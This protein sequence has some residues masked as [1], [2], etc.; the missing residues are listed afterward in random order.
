MGLLNRTARTTQRGKEPGPFSNRQSRAVCHS[1]FDLNAFV[2]SAKLNLFSSN[3]RNALRLIAQANRAREARRWRE[4]GELYAA[5]L[6]RQPGNPA[7]HIQCG[8]MFKEAGEYES[9]ETHYLHARI[10]APHDADLHLQLGHFYKITGRLYESFSAYER[11]AEL[12]PDWNEPQRELKALHV[13]VQSRLASHSFAEVIE[14][15]DTKS[16]V[17]VR[18]ATRKATPPASA[19]GVGRVLWLGSNALSSRRE[20]ESLAGLGFEIIFRDVAASTPD[21]GGAPHFAEERDV[22]LATP[23]SSSWREMGLALRHDFAC[24]VVENDVGIF[25]EYI[26]SFP[27][28]IVFRSYGISRLLGD[29]LWDYGSLELARQ[30]SNIVYMPTVEQVVSLEA[31]WLQ[32]SATVLPGLHAVEADL[33]HLRWAGPFSA[34][35]PAAVVVPHAHDPNNNSRRHRAFIQEAF[36]AGDSFRHIDLYRGEAS[37]PGG[38]LLDDTQLRAVGETTALLYADQTTTMV[39]GYAQQALLMG[40]PIVYLSGS[41]LASFMGGGAG[42]AATL[43]QAH[44]KIGRLIANQGD[45]L[46]NILRHQRGIAHQLSAAQERTSF[47]NAFSQVLLSPLD[48]PAVPLKLTQHVVSANWQQLERLA[49]CFATGLRKGGLDNQVDAT[50]VV[51]CMFHVVLQRD[52]SLDEL[53]EYLERA[54]G[55]RGAFRVF[56]DLLQTSEGQALWPSNRMRIWLEEAWLADRVTC[57]S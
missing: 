26:R 22:P 43:A 51:Q 8:H 11:A 32:Q 13:S 21:K 6:R 40:V 54:T 47:A 14:F 31:P 1:W 19:M 4:A 9:A 23:N 12:A 57:S 33:R 2:R 3:R 36:P 29:M 35:A 49:A 42:E 44:D 24:V 46:N 18:A 5:A 25:A 20:R 10:L 34:R 50:W 28:K 30:R 52:P 39:H 16:R 45:L 27:G 7:I 38:I 17:N 37:G 56:N 53:G 55:P 48:E 41:L 15:S